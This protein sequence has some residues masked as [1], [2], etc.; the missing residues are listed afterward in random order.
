MEH[1]TSVK[2][3]SKQSNILIVFFNGTI[4]VVFGGDFVSLQVM[5]LFD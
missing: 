4:P 3:Q 5:T 2:Y 1:F